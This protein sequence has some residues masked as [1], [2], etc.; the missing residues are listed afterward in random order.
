MSI[1]SCYYY[2]KS[3]SA[4]RLLTRPGWAGPRRDGTESLLSHFKVSWV[5]PI[6]TLS[7]HTQRKRER[8]IFIF[9]HR[10]CH[11]SSGACKIFTPLRSK[12]RDKQTD[13]QFWVA[14]KRRSWP[15]GARTLSVWLR[16]LTLTP[17]HP[18]TSHYSLFTCLLFTCLWLVNVKSTGRCITVSTHTRGFQFHSIRELNRWSAL[19]CPALPC[20][21][22]H[23]LL[24]K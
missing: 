8:D 18:D 10:A 5:V 14:R 2:V 16:M 24:Y 23:L 4:R 19:P 15:K 20:P 9:M 12:Q 13:R 21:A 17:W 22:L 1:D 3:S 6:V 11:D 7:T